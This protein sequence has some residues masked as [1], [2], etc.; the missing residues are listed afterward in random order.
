MIIHDKKRLKDSELLWI[1]VPRKNSV[2]K[3]SNISRMFICQT[4]LNPNLK[5]FRINDRQI[6]EIFKSK[7]FSKSYSNNPDF[8]YTIRYQNSEEGIAMKEFE[9][10]FD[11]LCKTVK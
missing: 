2:S 1:E 11:E 6:I 4:V 3:K 8:K 9:L 10:A 7:V 5:D